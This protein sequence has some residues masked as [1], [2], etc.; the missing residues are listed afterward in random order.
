[1]TERDRKNGLK[2]GAFFQAHG[3][4]PQEYPIKY[5]PGQEQL[6]DYYE[7]K[8]KRRLRILRKVCILG[9]L[10]LAVFGIVRWCTSF[11]PIRSYYKLYQYYQ[12]SILQEKDL[13][14]WS[15]LSDVMQGT[16]NGTSM[17][18]CQE[19]DKVL[20]YID[21]SVRLKSVVDADCSATNGQYLYTVSRSVKKEDHSIL[22]Q[23][24]LTI[25]SYQIKAGE[26]SFV[27]EIDEDYTGLSSAPP[28]VLY[29]YG[30]TLAVVYTESTVKDGF[31]SNTNIEFY[32]L[33]DGVMTFWSK[34]V[35]SGECR[36]CRQV[37]G[38]LYVV[39]YVGGI[40]KSDLEKTENYVPMRSGEKMD[41]KDIYRLKE[42]QGN[43]YVIVSTLHIGGSFADS[44]ALTGRYE[45]IY[46]SR[47]NLYLCSNHYADTTKKESSD[48]IQI[49]KLC[50]EDDEIKLTAATTF[51]GVQSHNFA[52]QETGDVLWVAA[53]VPRYVSRRGTVEKWIEGRVYTFDKQLRELDHLEG[54][55]KDEDIFEAKFIGSIGYLVANGSE[56]PLTR[57][58][59]SDPRHLK[60]LEEQEM[61][62]F[63]SYYYSLQEGLILGLGQSE[64]GQLR[65]KLYDGSDP[66]KLV[67]RQE[68]K[69]Q[70][71]ASTCSVLQ[72]YRWVTVDVKNQLFGFSVWEINF[73]EENRMIPNAVIE[74]QRAVFYL[75]HYDREH[76][77]EQV[78]RIKMKGGED[79]PGFWKGYRVGSYLYLVNQGQKKHKLRIES[80]DG[81]IDM[82]K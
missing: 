15:G 66:G 55:M 47:N 79:T 42:S 76:G 74:S 6:I 46:M 33:Y 10:F 3:V 44:K 82:K 2:R 67:C 19:N 57:V 59:L 77:L 25:T 45:N 39:S 7:Q 69:L 54:L 31:R 20:S 23:Y 28:P 75:Y 72:D 56:T 52:I 36:L 16:V 58:D 81:L 49:V 68:I 14:E 18:S 35:Q 30:A 17:S 9:S 37:D 8:R 21:T 27:S 71:M 60:V 73:D 70:E 80:L 24:R 38:R 41:V 22:T 78:R 63:S 1:M 13:S 48:R 4:L 50:C 12:E 65:M 51:P 29:L 40:V 43:G 62:G 32:D 64:N 5:R 11:H 26:L 61:P 34:E 53:Q